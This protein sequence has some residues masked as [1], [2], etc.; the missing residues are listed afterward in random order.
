MVLS[1][2]Q[3]EN[4]HTVFE[5]V[6]GLALAGSTWVGVLIKSALSAIRLE[7]EQAKAELLAHQNAVKDEVA[8][9]HTEL[10]E[11]QHDLQAE[12]REKH[13]ENKQALAVHTAEDKEKFEGF[14]RTLIRMEGKLDKIANGH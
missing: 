14:S 6:S 2:L 12:F 10:L 4:L 3:G 11:G 5:I 8:E 7:Q 1:F 9:Q 13:S